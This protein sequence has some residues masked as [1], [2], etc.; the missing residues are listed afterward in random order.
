MGHKRSSTGCARQVSY[1]T[2]P[3]MRAREGLLVLAAVNM[4][5]VKAPTIVVTFPDFRAEP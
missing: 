3:D 4:G 1:G 2:G 5:R